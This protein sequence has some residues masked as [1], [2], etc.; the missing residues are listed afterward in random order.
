MKRCVG[1]WWNRGNAASPIRRSVFCSLQWNACH[2]NAFQWNAC[3]MARRIGF[4][5]TENVFLRMKIHTEKEKSFP[6]RSRISLSPVESI[7]HFSLTVWLISK[8]KHSTVNR[9]ADSKKIKWL[10]MLSDGKSDANMC[11][12]AKIKSNSTANANSSVKL[13]NYS[14]YV[15][16]MEW[17]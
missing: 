2:W 13:I 10:S 1:F 16:Q 4:R 3:E 15:Q 6:I 9:A 12:S 5:I 17:R 8:L 11:T 14:F 7:G